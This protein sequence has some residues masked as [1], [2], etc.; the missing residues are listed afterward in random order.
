MDKTHE[1]GI[2]ITK[3]EMKKAE[4]TKSD[5]KLFNEKAPLKN[6]IKTEFT[7]VTKPNTKKSIPMMSK[8]PLEV[9]DL[10]VI[11]MRL[12]LVVQCKNRFV[13]FPLTSSEIRNGYRS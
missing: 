9:F 11:G 6:A 8:G 12:V 4:V 13:G 1:D 2:A 3:Y 5:W 7:H 10:V